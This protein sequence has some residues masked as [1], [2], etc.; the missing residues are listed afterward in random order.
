MAETGT[1]L[2]HVREGKV[3]DVAAGIGGTLVLPPLSVNQVEHYFGKVKGFPDIA[4][5]IDIKNDVPA[6]TSV[7]NLN[8]SGAMRYGNRRTVPHHV[9]LVWEKLYQGIQRNRV[10]V[11]NRELPLSKDFE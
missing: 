8:P 11:F 9:D 1:E 10:L 7:T 6:K 3:G 2:L 5:L 4:E